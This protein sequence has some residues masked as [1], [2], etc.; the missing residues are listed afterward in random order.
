[1]LKKSPSSSMASAAA[2]GSQ[3]MP[4][5]RMASLPWLMS[6]TLTMRTRRGSEACMTSS[7]VS[8]RLASRSGLMRGQTAARSELSQAADSGSS[9]ARDT[10]L[11]RQ[12]G[13]DGGRPGEPDGEAAAADGSELPAQG[14]QL[15]RR[16]A[17]GEGVAAPLGALPRVLE[18]VAGAGAEAVEVELV[19]CLAGEVVDGDGQVGDGIGDVAQPSPR[20]TSRWWG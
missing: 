19:E 13:D 20:G 17:G 16:K 1:M 4:K 3:R 9:V 8:A 18:L 11:E 14:V 10:P 7:S 12:R 6:S 5:M 15:G 2:A